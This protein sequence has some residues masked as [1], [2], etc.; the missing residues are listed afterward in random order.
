MLCIAETRKIFPE[1]ICRY[2]ESK[3]LLIR[4][5]DSPLSMWHS[6]IIDQH[7]VDAVGGTRRFSPTI[8][9]LLKLKYLPTFLLTLPYH[10]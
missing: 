3:L 10:R 4:L 8:S 2:A 5:G 9:T 6:I 7:M 1:L